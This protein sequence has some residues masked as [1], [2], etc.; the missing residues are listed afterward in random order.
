MTNGCCLALLH[1]QKAPRMMSKRLSGPGH[2]GILNVPRPLLDST[3]TSLPHMDEILYILEY[4]FQ[5]S[6]SM[7]RDFLAVQQ[8]A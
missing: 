1:A 8:Q 4:C 5:G 2:S 3:P 7:R 6:P